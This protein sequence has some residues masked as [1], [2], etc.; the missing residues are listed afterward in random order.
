ML[1]TLKMILRTLLLPPAGPLLAAAFGV[2]L[3]RRRT[4]RA[5]RTGWALRW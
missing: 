2:W 1:I 5:R 3:S 4:P